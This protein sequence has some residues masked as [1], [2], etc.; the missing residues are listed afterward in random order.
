[1][2]FEL[3]TTQCVF[4]KLSRKTFLEILDNALTITE[5]YDTWDSM[6][7]YTCEYKKYWR[8]NDLEI[9]LVVYA[10]TYKK[11]EDLMEEIKNAHI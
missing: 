3:I 8:F 6:D 9:D 10:D 1:M 5:N 4:S 7:G 2:R 11:I